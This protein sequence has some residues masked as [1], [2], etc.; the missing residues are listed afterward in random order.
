M[1]RPAVALGATV[2]TA[3]CSVGTSQSRRVAPKLGLEEVCWVAW[4]DLCMT[5]MNTNHRKENIDGEKLG[6]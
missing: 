1:Q 3:I 5:C 2:Y 4:G 6:P